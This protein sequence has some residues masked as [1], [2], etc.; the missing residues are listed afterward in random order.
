MLA[1]TLTVPLIPTA[2]VHAEGP[3][4]PAPVINPKVTN[5]NNGK[6]ILFDN[7]H[8][9]TAGAAD[10]V[11]DGGFSDF[12]NGLAGAGYTVTE[13]RKTTPITLADLQPYD[14]FII[15]EANNPYKV[16]EQQAMIQY[17]QGGGSIFFIADHYNADRNKNRWDASEVMN[18]FRR[19]AWDDPAKGM[20]TEERNSAPMQ[21]VQ[22][23][24][25][26]A[27]NFG[28]RFRYNALGDID[29][30][31]I[32]PPAQSFGITQGVGAV[33]MHAG[34]TLAIIDPKKAKGL[35]YLPQTNQ[36][37]ANAVDQG[38][39]SGGGVP[40]GPFSAIAKVGGGKAAFIGDSSPIEDATPKYVREENGKAKTTYDGWKE[41]NDATY[42]VNLVNWLAKKET[43]TSLDQVAGL[44]LDQPTALL[45]IE[46]PQ[47]TTEPA[48]EPW[49]PP[50][51]GYKWYDPTTFKAG[52]YGSSQ[53]PAVNPTYST[54]KQAT[55]P[56]NGQ[57]FPIRIVAD[58]LTPGAT[59]SNFNIGI[60]L[61]GGTQIGMVQNPD[62]T[63]P[64]S[65]GYS[66]SFSLTADGFGHATRDLTV[67][68]KPG[69][70]GTASLRLRQGSNALKTE[71][72]TLGDVPAEALPK[73]QPPIPAKVTIAEARKSAANSIVTVEG[74]ITTQ[75][76]IFGNQAFYLQDDTGGLYVFQNTAGFNAGDRVQ[77]SAPIVPYNNELELSTPIHME[78]TG[79]A[80]LPARTVITALNDQNQGQQVTLQNV[81]I[82]NIVSAAPTGSFEFDAVN[83]AG[84]TNHVRVDARTGLTQTAFPYSEGQMVNV[85][86]VSSI[87]KTGYLLRVTSPNDFERVDSTPPVT[88]FGLSGTPSANGWFRQDV[89]VTLTPTDDESG[90]ARTEYQL[91]PGE[92]FTPYT[93]PIVLSGEGT[94]TVS[95]RS[96]DNK[97]NVEASKTITVKIDKTAPTLTLEQNG[98]PAVH[99]VMIDGTVGFKLTG[100]DT[101]SGVASQT[102]LLDDTKLTSI[103]ETSAMQLGLGAHRVSATVT[104]NAGNVAE[105][106]VTFLIETSIPTI[107]NLTA[108]LQNQ[109]EIKNQGIRTSIDAKLDTAQ[110]FLDKG[111]KTQAAQHLQQLKDDLNNNAAN[112]NVTPNAAKI[113]N[114]NIDYLLSR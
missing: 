35:V 99:N 1:L 7:T 77:I 113:L 29:A 60:Y 67:K 69:S 15:G 75:P 37:W 38:V 56:N 14:V 102:L 40:E 2:A 68:L 9:Q 112:G 28:V 74:V 94:T 45:P 62:G 70:T 52:S 87:Y 73:D 79:T 21:N 22:S 59:L 103:S 36:S 6:K 71:T 107:K 44:Q 41:A 3:N 30:T 89:T 97:G 10:W 19:G 27:T 16:S 100:T 26:L 98:G 31:N 11:I 66:P 81:I 13:L 88:A 85:S 63:Y 23:S 18:G 24:D 109:N 90:V 110:K 51:S 104:D 114:A 12:A 78:K 17:V 76:G 86:G 43:Y 58:S 54:V 61:T 50:E 65:Y 83:A 32:V 53:A 80:N 95:Y 49:A 84:E 82:K 20:S 33:A 8:G 92:A 34:A 46:T 91:T 4:D 5:E 72:V 48:A 42:F 57:E 25:W 111:D 64:T 47:Q 108:Q 105:Q 101:G 96:V 55:L 106:N 93:A 39:Y